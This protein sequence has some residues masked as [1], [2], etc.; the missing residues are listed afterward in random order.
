MKHAIAIWV[1]S[2]GASYCVMELTGWWSRVFFAGVALAL[3]IGILGVRH[4][5][6]Q[7]S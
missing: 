3:A 4:M 2:A 1:M 7:K 6:R 5:D